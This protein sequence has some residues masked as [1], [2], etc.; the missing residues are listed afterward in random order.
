MGKIVELRTDY[1]YEDELPNGMTIQ[2]SG[3]KEMIDHLLAKDTEIERLRAL[4]KA[5]LHFIDVNVADP[6]ITNEM[7]EA[8]MALQELRQ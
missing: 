4:T 6:D 7:A 2:V 5:A 8:W 1:A 3:S